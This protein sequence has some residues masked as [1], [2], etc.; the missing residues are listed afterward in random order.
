VSGELPGLDSLG[1]IDG[2]RIIVRADLNVP[3]AAGNVADDSRI[4]ASIPTLRELRNRGASVVI[5]SHL[6]RPG[7]RVEPELSLAPVAARLREL[8]S[9][10]VSFVGDVAG[11]EAR[12]AAFTLASG[13]VLVCEN[14]RFEPAETTKDESQRAAFAAELALLGD[15]F[16][17]DAF[18][19]VHRR[20]ASVYD[21]PARLPHA[22]GELVRREV[23]LLSRLTGDPGRPYTVVLGG[24]KVSDKLGVIESLLGR[25]D[26]LLVGGGMCFTFLAAQ[27]MEV[28]SS[29]LEADQI[30]A[31]RR[32]LEDAKRRNV[33][34]LLPTDVAVAADPGSPGEVVPVER[35]PQ[36]LRGLDIG[37]VAA[38]AFAERIGRAATVFWNGPMGVFEAPGFAAG[39]RTVAEAVAG[40]D[41]RG[42]FSVVGGGDSA[43]ALHAFGFPDDR[44]THVSTGGGASLEFLEGR[45]LPGLTALGY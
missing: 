7:G 4:R 10:P 22:A 20:H 36:G 23:S 1:D 13:G 21:L 31:C 26:E 44:F 12:H 2:C 28:G 24:A 18:G 16:V 32:F 33:D 14:L 3:L 45:E 15:A 25:V 37:P 29:L 35:I 34:L 5:L 30:D 38:R 17:E 9:F 42:G 6:G 27:E 8:T 11:E 43:A 39:T 41:A 40:V 19:A